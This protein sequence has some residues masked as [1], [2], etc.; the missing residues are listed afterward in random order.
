MRTLLT[1]SLALTMTACN[2]TDDGTDDTTD[3]AVTDDTGMTED[4]GEV[5]EVSAVRVVH[6]SPGAPPVDVYVAGSADPLISDLAYGET[7]SFTDLPHGSYD[8]E[9]RAAG[10]ASDSAPAYTQTVEVA[11]D[12]PITVV[13]H[14]LLG[15]SGAEAFTLTP[16]V[17]DFATPASGTARV[18]ILHAS[19]TA[20]AVAIDVGNDGT[21]ELSDV[22]YGADSGAAGVELPAGESIAIG[23]WAGETSLS[24][25][26]SFTT[27]ALP[28]GGELWVI[29][30]GLLEDLAREETGFSLLAVAPT[31]SIG[32]IKQ[33]PV[34]YA[35]HAG[36]DAPAVDIFAG[37][38]EL[39]DNAAFGDISAPVRVPPGSYDLEFYA[40][41][42]GSTKP[43]V[44][45]AAVQST[46]ELAAGERYLAIATG[47]LSDT[48]A[49]QLVPIAEGFE[50][51]GSDARLRVV[52]ASPDAPT[53]DI[54]TVAS[55]VL[56]PVAD[57]SGA[58]FG[59]ASAAGGVGLPTGSYDI[60]VAAA[61]STSPLFTFSGLGL[62]A[63][64][65]ITAVAA[66]SVTAGEFQLMLVDMSA[67]PW[68]VVAVTPDL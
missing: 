27:P 62:V 14:G 36:A 57:F 21:P 32:F 15:G 8:L 48:P 20:P 12:M 6:A 29:A 61:N 45:P 1:L 46:P 67:E 4:T 39:V 3:D 60:G 11:G 47:F 68:G 18:R 10:S 64:D 9:L 34:V 5:A 33:D 25:V 53:V 63:G 35:L 16:F 26:T 59:D 49:F 66:G 23:I 55:G 28:D 40:H 51:D 65:Q 41:T 42:V 50:G 37:T 52:H 7:T 54:G 17:E 30:T 38:T 31:G 43:G 2:G 19:P 13:A 24:R 58:S 22:G 44:S 56:T